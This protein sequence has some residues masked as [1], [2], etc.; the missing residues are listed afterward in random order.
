[1]KKFYDKTW[2]KIVLVMVALLIIG[3]LFG[4]AE[5]PEAKPKAEKAAV[6]AEKASESPC[7]NVPKAKVQ[8][9]IEGF[10]R[11]TTAINAA[12]VKS[13]FWD[14]TYMIAV[15][16]KTDGFTDVGVWGSD[17]LREGLLFAVD[18]MAQE[19]TDY[20]AEVNGERL[21]ITLDGAQEAKE[22]L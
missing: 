14:G 6:Q 12:A 20:P 15:E 10:K 21:D 1:M 4:G 18:G 17:S 2:K 13:D 8:S 9:I 16:F 3:S 19:F 11:P 5:Q 22:C 7:L